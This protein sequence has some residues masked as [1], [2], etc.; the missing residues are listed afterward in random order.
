MS[1]MFCV[2]AV[3]CA[4]FPQ[5]QLTPSVSAVL[6]VNTSIVPP[7]YMMWDVCL[8][9][10]AFLT[11]I[12][13]ACIPSNSCRRVWIIFQALK[14]LAYFYFCRLSVWTIVSLGAP[15]NQI[16]MR[17]LKVVS[18]SCMI[19]C[20]KEWAFI[21][22]VEYR[23]MHFSLLQGN[24]HD[25]LQTKIKLTFGFDAIVVSSVSNL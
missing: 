1:R 8:Y 15:T 14:F 21:G 6:N 4:K 3:F 12:W 2:I 17:E 20:S 11:C 19:H 16:R 23:Y 7:V 10:W 9:P 22:K 25:I 18:V 24:S 5:N 13:L